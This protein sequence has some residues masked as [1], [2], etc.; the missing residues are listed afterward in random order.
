MVLLAAATLFGA[1]LVINWTR[2]TAEA[3]AGIRFTLGLFF[4][5]LLVI[6]RKRPEADGGLRVPDGVVP[7]ALVV[8]TLAALC[9][10]ILPVHTLEW[11]GVLLMLLACLCWRSTPRARPDLM[12]ATFMLFWVHPLPG[13]LFDGLQA[14]MQRLSVTGSELV[15]H[16]LNVRVWGDG[17]I[18]RTGYQNFLVPEACSGM[19]TSVT[20]FLCALGVSLLLRLRWWETLGVVLLGLVQVLVL[21]IVR[22]SYMVLWAPRMEREW[23]EHFL[24]DSLGLFLLAAIVL[25]QVEAAWW[26]W[27]TRRRWALREGGVRPDKELPDHAS[28]IPH[29]L[30]RLGFIL[31]VLSGLGLVGFGSFVIAYK[32]RTYH[33]KEMIREVA[34]GLMETDPASAYRAFAETLRYFPNDTELLALQASTDL[35][36]GRFDDGLLLLDALERVGGGLGLRETVMKSWAL[37]RVGR[38]P[39]AR[40][41]VNALPQESDRLPG[42]AM[43]KA[44]FAAMDG[45]PEE[46]ARHLRVASGSHMMLPRIRALFPYL[47]RHE[48]WAAIAVADHDRPYAE[49]YQALIALYATQQVNNFSKMVQVM[50]QA[51]KA[52]PDDPRFMRSLF[53][54]ASRRRE[55]HWMNQFERS[56]RANIDKMPADLASEAAGYCW[57]LSRPDLAW[58]AYLRLEKVSPG[59]PE[60]L[61]APALHGQGW[62]RFPRRDLSIQSDSFERMLDLIPVLNLFSRTG[63]F[64]EFRQRIPMIDDVSASAADRASGRIYLEKG[65]AA[66]TQR[67]AQGPLGERFMRLYPVVLAMLNRFDEAHERLDRIRTTYPERSAEILFQH[68]NLYHQQQDWQRAYEMLVEYHQR[69]GGANLTVELLRVSVLMNLDLGVCA[70]QVH[71]EA[72]RAFPGSERLDLAESAIWDAFGFSAQALHVLSRAPAGSTSPAAINLLYATGRTAQARQL[73]SA[74]RIA[75]AGQ[76]VRPSPPLWLPPASFVLT[77]RWPPPLDAVAL[78]TRRESLKQEHLQATSPYVKALRGVMLA[79]VE[80]QLSAESASLRADASRTESWLAAWESVGRTPLEK[81]G[82]LYEL[83]M[84]SARQQDLSLARTALQRTLVHSPANP[85]IWRALV[86]LSEKDSAVVQAAVDKCPADPELVLAELVMQV[87]GTADTNRWVAVQQR[88]DRM[89]ADDTFA[90]EVLIRAG[91]FL[92]SRNRADRVEPLVRA[93][94]SR[95]SGLLVAHVF[96]LRSAILRGEPDKALPAVLRCIEQAEDPVPFYRIMV[97]LKVARRQV[98][99]DLL[100][101]L[102]YLQAHRKDEP[103]WAEL[104]GSLYFHK[105]DMR[106]SLNVL[107]TAIGSDVKRVRLQTL[108]LAAEAARLDDKTDRAIQLM[109]AAYSLYPQELGVLNNLVYVLAQNPKTLARARDLLP[110]LLDTGGDQFAVMDT[111]AMVA[112]R[113]GDTQQ[114]EQWMS[115]AIENLKGDGYAAREVQLNAAELKWRLGAVKEARQTIGDLRMDP[116]RSDFIDQRSRRLLRDIDMLNQD[117][118]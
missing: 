9:G 78:Q 41:L 49:V 54:I 17:T 116:Q 32:S 58:L 62:A 108:L 45:V 30:R 94:L 115:K 10:I 68:A 96:A 35:L 72:R 25:V 97:E 29:P 59:D 26:R 18:L 82:A 43:L 112:L 42:V 48:Q 16:V 31:L 69:G 81:T 76:A 63:P 70:M 65:L 102:E 98:D 13:T 105:G 103:R 86:S 20:V 111:A 110:K 52:W 85:V 39:E 40:A 12:L 66:L 8:G 11:G 33:R 51:L 5:V 113:S 74:L 79:W 37:S 22:I 118:Q 60:R 7:W 114:A 93:A 34:S 3:D 75:P 15:L 6:R 90:P 46:A 61:I 99:N 47:A 23:A 64:R 19:R 73:E 56:F 77:P 80:E 44:E 38:V 84:L 71:E 21:N 55:G 104:L 27:W 83:A 117:V 67:E 28:I 109:E 107:G 95:A 87:D 91:D 57:R 106:R 53:E 14:V 88:V 92:L 101:A 1:W 4:C 36:L 100:G 50:E 89:A 2:V 24:H